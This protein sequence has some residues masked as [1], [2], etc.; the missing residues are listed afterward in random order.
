MMFTESQAAPGLLTAALQSQGKETRRAHGDV[1][2]N[3]VHSLPSA[4]GLCYVLQEQQLRANG[5]NAR[6]YLLLHLTAKH[7]VHN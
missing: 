1:H 5:L 6:T 3:E 4:P 2:S 7:P